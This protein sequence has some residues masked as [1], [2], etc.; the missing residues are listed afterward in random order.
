MLLANVN[1]HNQAFS[2]FQHISSTYQHLLRPSKL[3]HIKRHLIIKHI[4]VPPIIIP[5][6]INVSP[7]PPYVISPFSISLVANNTL[8]FPSFVCP[9]VNGDTKSGGARDSCLSLF[10]RVNG[11]WKGRLAEAG[12]RMDVGGSSAMELGECCCRPVRPN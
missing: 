7:R 12:I 3:H 4:Q 8:P 9:A 5:R 6:R 11:Y 1:S 2:S 10:M